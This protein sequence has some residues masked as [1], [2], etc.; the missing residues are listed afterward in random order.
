MFNYGISEKDIRITRCELKKNI[1]TKH[2]IAVLVTT[3]VE[4]LTWKWAGLAWLM[5]FAILFILNSVFSEPIP[6]SLKNFS[7]FVPILEKGLFPFIGSMI[8]A[9]AIKFI[10]RMRFYIKNNLPIEKLPRKSSDFLSSSRSVSGSSMSAN[11]IN[12]YGMCGSVDSNGN[13]PGHRA[14]RY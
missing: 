6:D 1:H 8:V 14:H 2:P 4:N 3:Q 7:I 5:T 10:T 13:A 12:G 11:P 9:A